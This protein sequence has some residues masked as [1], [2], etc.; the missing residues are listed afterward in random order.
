MLWNI[1]IKYNVIIRNKHCMIHVRIAFFFKLIQLPVDIKIEYS[2]FNGLLIMP[3]KGEYLWRRVSRPWKQRAH[4]VDSNP[5]WLKMVN[6]EV[7]GNIGLKDDSFVAVLL[8]GI[9]ECLIKSA[10]IILL[11]ARQISVSI[12]PDFQ[13]D[14]FR[15]NLEGIFLFLP[16]QIIGGLV[17]DLFKRRRNIKNVAS[18]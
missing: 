2:P 3:L 16:T 9:F 10:A 17:G 13:K 5:K 11:Q 18:D 1:K 12:I 15:L 6:F 7:S 4:R 14:A 8:C